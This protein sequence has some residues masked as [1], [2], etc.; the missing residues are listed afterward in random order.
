MCGTRRKAFP[1]LVGVLS[2][3]PD[4]N[5]QLNDGLLNA[6]CDKYFSPVWQSGLNAIWF[7]YWF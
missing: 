5:K 4:E 2:I 3:Q 1:Y 7:K 6:H